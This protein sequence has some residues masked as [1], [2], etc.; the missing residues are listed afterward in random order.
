MGEAPQIM[1]VLISIVM[2]LRMGAK[3]VSR[4]KYRAWV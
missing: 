2:G 3:Q 4:V 1:I